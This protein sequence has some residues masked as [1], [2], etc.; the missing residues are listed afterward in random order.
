MWLFQLPLP[1]GVSRE[2]LQNEFSKH[3]GL[4]GKSG[5]AITGQNPRHYPLGAATEPQGTILMLSQ[6]SHQLI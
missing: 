4:T 6:L 2:H 3:S 1:S 5:I